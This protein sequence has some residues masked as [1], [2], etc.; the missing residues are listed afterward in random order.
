[1][2]PK[3]S[4]KAA[5][6]WFPQEQEQTAIPSKG[7]V[8]RLTDFYT[9]L[10]GGSGSGPQSP[11]RRPPGK[12]PERAVAGGKVARKKKKPPD[13]PQTSKM[14]ASLRNFLAASSRNKNVLTKECDQ[15]EGGRMDGPQER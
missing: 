14:A 5:F 13:D 3:H 11:R 12:P 7:T 6:V 10:G 1:M 15:D 8:R 9:R 4:D 2:R